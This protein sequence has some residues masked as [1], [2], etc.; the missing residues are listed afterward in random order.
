MSY[1]Y[2][3]DSFQTEDY[4]DII[5]VVIIFKQKTMRIMVTIVFKLLSVDMVTI[6]FKQIT[7]PGIVFCLETIVTIYYVLYITVG[8]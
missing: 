3:Y 2:G 5:M 4:T 8:L 1:I 7:I 6:V